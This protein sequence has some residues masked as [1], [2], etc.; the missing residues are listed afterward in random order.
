MI[1]L[2]RYQLENGSVPVTEWL[3]KLRDARVNAMIQI[4]FKRVESGNFGDHKPVGEGVSELRV[5]A[6]AGYRVYYG[7][8]DKTLVVLLCGGD[9]ATQQADIKQAKEYWVDWKRKNI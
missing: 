9:K 3:K 4:R 7:L 2:L 1:E 5:N 8:R 6:G